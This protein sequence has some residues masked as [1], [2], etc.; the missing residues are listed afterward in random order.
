MKRISAFICLV[1]LMG[2]LLST[3]VLGV[4]LSIPQADTVGI[5]E[6]E[7]SIPDSARD[8]LGDVSVD[9]V[10]NGE[11]ILDRLL[12]KTKGEL[13]DVLTAGVRNAAAVMMIAILCACAGQFSSDMKIPDFVPLAGML[14]VAAV[15]LGDATSFVAMSR[16]AIYELSDFSKVLLPSMAAASAAAG[17]VAAGAAKYAATALFMDMLITAGSDLVFPMVCLYAGTAVADAALGNGALGMAVKLIKWLC[18]TMLTLLVMAF[19]AY[20]SISGAI[21]GSADAVAYRA[22]KAGLST[23]LPVVGGIISDAAGAVAAGA[24]ILKGTVGVFGL[25]A[26]LCVCLIPIL[27]LGVRYLLFKAVAG[28]AGAMCAPAMSKLIGDIGTVYGMLLA[29][30]GSGAVMMFISVISGMG[31]VSG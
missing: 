9:Q 30:V 17:Q 15:S 21:A 14:A 26:V 20:L 24:S 29:L 8:V 27:T 10:L 31:A 22:A 25:V 12:E 3:A 23:V 1:P 18:N 16:K 28:L 6:L 11:N 4:D 5:P 19:T 13:R 7:A 2:I